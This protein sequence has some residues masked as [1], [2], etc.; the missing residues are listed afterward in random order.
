MSE[1]AAVE[2]AWWQSQTASP[3]GRDRERLRAVALDK[4]GNERQGI[5]TGRDRTWRDCRYRSLMFGEAEEESEWQEDG[6]EEKERAGSDRDGVEAPTSPARDVADSKQEAFLEPSS[7]KP[8]KEESHCQHEQGQPVD[9]LGCTRNHSSVH[10]TRQPNYLLP[11]DTPPA[12]LPHHVNS[13]PSETQAA[14]AEEQE[15]PSSPIGP[16][17]T[18][19]AYPSDSPSS[20]L[21]APSR[22]ANMRQ[23]HIS[24]TAAEALYLSREASEGEGRE[25]RSKGGRKG[26]R[27]ERQLMDAWSW[28]G[29]CDE[30]SRAMETGDLL[31]GFHEVAETERE[32]WGG[33]KEG[34]VEE[35][36]MAVKRCAVAR[37]SGA[38]STREEGSGRGKAKLS[39]WPY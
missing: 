18:P 14:D 12:S 35:C 9:L 10:S 21:P 3:T 20:M 38:R 22:L 32:R 5:G 17:L 19:S 36:C 37:Q 28:I 11:V 29:K 1:S 8:G 13:L 6:K 33:W 2:A 23:R 39:I 7:P 26:G 25:V 4:G 24:F 31:F 34:R 15:A 27:K 16:D 30:L